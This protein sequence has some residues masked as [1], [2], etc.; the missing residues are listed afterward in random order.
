MIISVAKKLK[1]IINENRLQIL[2][3]IKDKEL[4]VGKIEENMQLS[5]S[6]LSQHLAI[7][8]EYDLV[9]TR[10]LSQTIFYQLKD[11]Q[12]AKLLEFMEQVF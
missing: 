4:S 10:R 5:Q 1:V 12:I 2:Y 3:L 7:L 9:K 6:A 8:R 11:K